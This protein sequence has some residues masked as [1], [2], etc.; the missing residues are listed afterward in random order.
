M[1]FWVSLILV[2]IALAMLFSNLVLGDIPWLRL[3]INS[4]KRIGTESLTR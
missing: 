1:L 4:F 3:F 2:I